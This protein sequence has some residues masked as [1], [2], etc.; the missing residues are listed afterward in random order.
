MGFGKSHG[1]HKH[2][3]GDKNTKSPSYHK[4]RYIIPRDHTRKN[5]KEP[6][7]HHEFRSPQKRAKPNNF[8]QIEVVGEIDLTRDVSPADVEQVAEELHT[9]LHM[10]LVRPQRVCLKRRITAKESINV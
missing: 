4:Q 5:D 9:P 1:F 10:P 8:A 3:A 7:H 6:S 2:K